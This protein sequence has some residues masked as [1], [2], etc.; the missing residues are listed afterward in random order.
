MKI[1]MLLLVE[2]HKSNTAPQPNT[3]RVPNHKQ[4]YKGHCNADA[5]KRLAMFLILVTLLGGFLYL[6]GIDKELFDFWWPRCPRLNFACRMFM[7]FAISIGFFEVGF[8]CF[9]CASAW[10]EDSRLQQLREKLREKK[11]G[12]KIGRCL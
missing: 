2:A 8:G 12:S 6:A 1:E 3:R 10:R 4:I 9:G 7:G 11:L 5:I